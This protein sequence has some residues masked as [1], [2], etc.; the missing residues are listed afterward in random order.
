ML[1][2]VAVNGPGTT[3]YIAA[4][5]ATPVPDYRYRSRVS[6][7]ECVA[8]DSYWQGRLVPGVQLIDLD[9]LFTPPFT[10]R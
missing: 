3:V 5:D 7:E 9:T 4:P 1:P 6:G 10:V 2:W 8:T